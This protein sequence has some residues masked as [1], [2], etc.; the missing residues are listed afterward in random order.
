VTIELKFW[1]QILHL[2][3]PPVCIL[4][5]ERLKRIQFSNSSKVHG[6]EDEIL[7]SHVV[8]RTKE[9]AS[10]VCD[11]A[12]PSSLLI[13]VSLL[14]L[15]RSDSLRVLDFGGASG[16]HFFQLK[17]IASRA[18]FDWRIVETKRMCNL[19]FEAFGS[20]DSGLRFFESID[21]ASEDYSLD[22]D[23][24]IAGSSLGY[25][26][27]PDG[28]LKQL[29]GLEPEVL[30]INRQVLTEGKTISMTQKSDLRANGPRTKERVEHSHRKVEV[31]YKLTV[32]NRTNFESL[33]VSS[34]YQ[35]LVRSRDQVGVMR[36]GAD[37]FDS[38]CY[39]A[40]RRL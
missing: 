26:S 35:F 29:L 39:L 28:T 10:D 34:G 21:E 31:Q 30:F 19:A 38:W 22:F 33:I 32:P 1:K 37:L 27:D 36:S 24:V 17:Q 7:V 4:L 23:L 16:A 6:Y 12:T 5:F 2:F 13:G 14:P 9:F 18:H 8:D 15:M 11:S 40:T 25:T 3:T 20:S